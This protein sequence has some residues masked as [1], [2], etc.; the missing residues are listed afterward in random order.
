MGCC[1]DSS[2]MTTG[3]VTSP[4]SWDC[5]RA[6]CSGC[7]L[8]AAVKPPT[9]RRMKSTFMD[10]MSGS[11]SSGTFMPTQKPVAVSASKAMPA[12]CTP[13]MWFCTLRRLATRTTTRP[14][15]ICS[16]RKPAVP[17]RGTARP[18]RKLTTQLRKPEGSGRKRATVRARRLG[19]TAPVRGSEDMDAAEP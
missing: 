8:A 1:P 18:N 13:P 4:L 6:I 17:T 3:T 15:V 10:L 9:A 2:V 7:R 14:D 16:K 11:L 19:R 5:I 12:A